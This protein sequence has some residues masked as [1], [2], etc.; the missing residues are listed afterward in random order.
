MP[1]F[2]GMAT[3]PDVA[4]APRV[5]PLFIVWVCLFGAF[6]FAAGT[7]FSAEKSYNL[8]PREVAP[9]TF[10]FE[11]RQ[12]YFSFENGGNIVN[13][14][15]IVTETGIIVIDTGPSRLYGE[16][17][18]AAIRQISVKPIVKVFNTHHHPDHFLG[19][20]AYFDTPITALS[21]TREGIVQEGDTFLQNMYRL[22]GDFMRGTEVFA[23]TESISVSVQTIAG[24]E[25]RFYALQGH[26]HADL[27]IFDPTTGVLF[28]GD[29]VFKF[30]APTTP[31]AHIGNW[32]EA[33]A[34]LEE[35]PFRVIVPG[36]GPVHRDQSGIAETRDYLTWLEAH[37]REALAAGADMMETMASPLPDRFA[38]WAVVKEEY[39]RSVSHLFPALEAEILPQVN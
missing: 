23:P 33:L 35:I 4:R 6:L 25:L 18:R 3:V 1:S 9:G 31:H 5:I 36:H 16:Q 8:S 22:A 20:Q 28:A 19:N 7:A 39:A 26:D 10:V 34:Q 17:M 15:F 2:P 32:L 12:E 27:A 13:T 29:L 30:Q 37:L 11:G 38:D 21:T 24:R 14:G